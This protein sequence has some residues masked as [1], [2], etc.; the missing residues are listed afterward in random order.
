MYQGEAGQRGVAT[1]STRKLPSPPARTRPATHPSIHPRV[2]PTPRKRSFLAPAVVHDASGFARRPCVLP[3]R[4]LCL[5]R[6][7][8]RDDLGGGR[9]VLVLRA[10]PTEDRF[11]LG[12]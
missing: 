11:G 3:Y 8:R 7:G 12:R 6:R 1:G 10:I 2:Q 9:N 4:V 5:V